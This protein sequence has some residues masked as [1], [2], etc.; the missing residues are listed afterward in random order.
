MVTD[1]EVNVLFVH[2]LSSLAKAELTFS[3]GA[4]FS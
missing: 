2:S 3:E 1:D 4:R